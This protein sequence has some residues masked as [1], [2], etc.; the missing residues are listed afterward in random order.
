MPAEI[1]E[2]GVTWTVSRAWPAPDGADLEAHAAGSPDVRGGR[3]S[4]SGGIRLLPAGTDRRLPALES[5]RREGAVVVH[6]PGR[7]AVVRSADGRSFLK[8]LRPHA[9]PGVVAAH[10]S[11]EVFAAGFDLPRVLHRADDPDGLVRF[12]ALP[13]RTL[14]EVGSDPRTTPERWRAVW[15]RWAEGWALLPPAPAELPEHGPAAE[16]DVVATWAAHAATQLPAHERAQVLAAAARV[17]ESLVAA[18]AEPLVLA[19]RDLHDKQLLAADDGSLALLDLDTAARAE[20][21]LD[22][23]NLRAHLRLRTAQG[24]LPPGRAAEA[25]AIVDRTAERAGVPPHR[26]HA[27]DTAARLRLACLYLFRPAWRSLAARSLAD[28]TGRILAP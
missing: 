24:L 6:R 22:L 26:L 21:A 5:A 16:S 11:A 8:V 25:A 7:R 9:A 28:T 3:W 19:H 2:D 12:A 17:S 15:E 20:A 23:G 4:A 14:L 10:A 27:H 18:P 13:G 1:V